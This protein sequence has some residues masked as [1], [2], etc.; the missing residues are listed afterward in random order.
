MRTVVSVPIV[1]L[2]VE[3]VLAGKGGDEDAGK[4]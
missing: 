4:V 1:P 3:L 2:D